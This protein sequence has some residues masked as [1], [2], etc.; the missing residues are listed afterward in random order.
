MCLSDCL[1]MHITSLCLN[2]FPVS[3]SC[4]LFLSGQ[5][6]RV[7]GSNLDL[8]LWLRQQGMAQP[9]EVC[10]ASQ[11]HWYVWLC[12]SPFPVLP[13][14]EQ[15]LYVWLCTSPFP[16]T[17]WEQSWYVWLCTSPF[18]TTA[19]E[20]SWYVWLCTCPFPVL[21]AWEQSWYVWLCTSPFPATA[22][23]QSWYVWLCTSPFPTTAW[24]QSWYVWLCTCP[25]PA[26]AW[27]QSWYVWLCDDSHCCLTTV[28]ALYLSLSHYCL[29]TELVRLALWWQPLLPDDSVST[30]PLTFPL[31]LENRAGISHFVL[32]ATAVWRQCQY[33]T[34]HFHSIA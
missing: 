7:H 18:P 16:A 8:S 31:L 10:L 19:W 12:T 2:A 32:A 20:Q 25:F 3:S 24:E 34:C 11:Q 23:E 4:I 15:S 26:T 6:P 13:A 33:C 29:R 28:S 21:P 27:E 22:W 1:S 9:G 17:A 14:W 30:L 5:A